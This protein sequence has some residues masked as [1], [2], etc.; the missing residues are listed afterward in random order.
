M[1]TKD[2]YEHVVSKLKEFC[3]EE[4]EFKVEI[5]ENTYPLEVR[6]T[7]SETQLSFFQ[8]KYINKDGEVGYVSVFCGI[9][10]T[11]KTNI[12]LVIGDA[13]FKKLINKAKEVGKYWLHY[14]VEESI[15][16]GKVKK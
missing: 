5:I 7:P 1:K 2:H 8:D 9:E 4:T 12:E 14:R 3:S 11:V 10:T 13:L 16:S 6:Y 15:R